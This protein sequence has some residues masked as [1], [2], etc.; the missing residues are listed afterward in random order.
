MRAIL[1]LSI[2]IFLIVFSCKKKEETRTVESTT[3][4]ST[5]TTGNPAPAATA[6][7]NALCSSQKIYSIIG[8]YTYSSSVAQ[9]SAIFTNSVLTNFNAY[10]GSYLAAGNISLN[11]IQL[12]NSASYYNDSTN[13][14]F[15]DPF[16]WTGTGSVIP[17]FSFTNTNA[18]ASYSGY[19][20]WPDTIKKTSDFSITLTSLQRADEAKL[21]V[22]VAGGPLV[23]T[24]T[25]LVS[26]GNINV[27]AVS[28]A[29]LSTSTQAIIQCDFFKNNIQTIGGKQVNFRNVTSFVKTAEVK[30]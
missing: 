30:N 10:A 25:A 27:S 4:L 11:G 22:S 14:V 7:F 28:I 19:V 13:S 23:Q 16:V 18:F 24:Y 29:A 2:I 5:S 3:Q 21:Y 26:S 9:N 6:T 15:S 1:T 20:S 17:A 8:N 12:K